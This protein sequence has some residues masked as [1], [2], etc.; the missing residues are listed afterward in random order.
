MD[1]KVLGDK[2]KTAREKKNMTQAEVAKKAGLNANYYA[3][4]E[5]GEKN[6]SFE[7]LNKLFEV[8]GINIKLG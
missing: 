7:N 1:K 6:I 2:L 5:R 8:L 3:I 4:V